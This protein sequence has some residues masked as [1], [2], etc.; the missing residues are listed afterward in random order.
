ML[1]GQVFIMDADYNPAAIT[2][3]PPYEKTNNLHMLISAYVFATQIVHFLL[4]SKISSL[5][6]S[7]VIV[8]PDLYLTWSRTRIVGFRKQRLIL[9]TKSRFPF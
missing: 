3:E 6:P 4:K 9:F 8:Q 7:S 2:F 5:Y 1:H